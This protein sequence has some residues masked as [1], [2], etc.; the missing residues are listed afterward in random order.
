MSLQWID[1][2]IDGKPYGVDVVFPGTFAELEAEPDPE[3]VLPRTH[4]D[5]VAKLV[6]GADIPR[7]PADDAASFVKGTCP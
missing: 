7:L 5:F 3:K 4:R 2:H 1:A 6:D